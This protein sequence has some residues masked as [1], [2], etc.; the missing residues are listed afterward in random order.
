MRISKNL[1]DEAILA[2]LGERLSRRR[3]ELGMTQARLAEESGVSKRTV[4]RIE[5][6][7]SAQLSSF[8]RLLRTL[9]LV[10]PIEAFVPDT[11][12]SPIE[13]LKLRGKQRER[14]SPEKDSDR[15]DAAWKWGDDA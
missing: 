15:P 6:G 10:D 3:I 2:Q 5:A 9:D 11:A 8:I 1:T 13:L 12:P 7:A 14:V 4:E